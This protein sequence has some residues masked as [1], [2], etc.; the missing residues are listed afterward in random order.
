MAIRDFIYL[1]IERVRSFYAQLSKGLVSERTT[2]KSSE[3]GA[4]ASVEGNVLFARGQGAI[5]YRYIRTN[6]E[7]VSLHDYIMEEFLD[8]LRKERLLIELPD[9]S[10]QWEQKSFRDG[11]FILL[12]GIVKII[13]YQYINSSLSNLPKLASSIDRLS[14]SSQGSNKPKSND[15]SKQIKD[16][17]ISDLT[18]FVEQNM[19]DILRIKVY[20]DSKNSDRNFVTDA[21]QDFFRYSTGS[22][23]SMYGNVIDAGWFCLLQVNQ[24]NDQQILP[25]ELPTMEAG[26]EIGALFE[27]MAD[28]LNTL[29]SIMKG[30]RFPSVAATPIALFREIE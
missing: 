27:Y 4:D 29:T 26:A 13:D 15:V 12:R 30:V 28:Q 14:K 11:M 25:S 7:T 2:E 6:T 9:S 3:V 16:L 8:K 1:D 20:P 19:Q 24:G 17:P 18:K 22:L 21:T 23:I 5:D 10:F